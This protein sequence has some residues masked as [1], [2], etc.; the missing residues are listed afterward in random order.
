MV[1]I[2]ILV[3]LVTTAAAILSDKINM[4]IEM[5]LSASAPLPYLAPL[6]SSRISEQRTLIPHLR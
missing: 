4:T 3:D 2:R 1:G 5:E 6:P